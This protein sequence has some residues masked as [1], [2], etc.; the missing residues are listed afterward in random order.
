MKVTYMG[1]SRFIGLVGGVL[2]VAVAGIVH[3]QEGP[4]SPNSAVPSKPVLRNR[5]K[6]DTHYLPRI[7]GEF[8]P[9]ESRRA[10]EQG[11]CVVRITVAVDGTTRDAVL[12]SSSGFPRLDEACLKA[13]VPGHMI[14]ATVNGTPVEDSVSV[15]INWTLATKKN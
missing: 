10:G 13:L 3:G 2:A 1:V 15:P 7:Y 6:Y 11:R 4:A 5:A 12:E 9:A 8:Y 14:P